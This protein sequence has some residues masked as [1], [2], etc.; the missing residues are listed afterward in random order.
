MLYESIA[1][2][3]ELRR[4]CRARK[5]CNSAAERAGVIV[6][7]SWDGKSKK[8]G[9]RGRKSP[10][11]ALRIKRCQMIKIVDYGMGNLRSVQKAFESLGQ[12]AEICDRAVELASA[13]KLVLP[14]VG[15]FRDAIHELNHKGMVNPIRDHLAAGK[16]FLGICLGLQLLFDV[17]YEDGE[18]PGLSIISGRVERFQN[19]PDIKIPQMGWNQLQVIGEP[20]LL[21]GIPQDAHFYFV[22]SYHVVPTDRSVVIADSE[23]GGSFVAAIGRGNLWATQFHPEKSQKHGLRLLANFASL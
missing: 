23:H 8:S 16:P 15:A 4:R 19:R 20:A 2:P 13:D 5:F 7:A 11:D 1:L 3:A 14:G 10:V 9:V 12:E 21:A 6:V 17:S 22:H 18:W